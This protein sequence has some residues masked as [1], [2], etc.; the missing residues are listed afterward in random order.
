M[1]RKLQEFEQQYSDTIFATLE[2]TL[3][4]SDNRIEIFKFLKVLTFKFF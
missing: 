3:A 1:S 2:S 4:D